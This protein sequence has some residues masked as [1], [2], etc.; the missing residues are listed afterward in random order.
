M[1]GDVS[2]SR[3]LSRLEYLVLTD[4]GRA[5]AC[6][7]PVEIPPY[8]KRMDGPWEAASNPTNPRQPLT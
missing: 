8:E 1:P 7:V 5:V 6:S 2:V 4:K 3:A